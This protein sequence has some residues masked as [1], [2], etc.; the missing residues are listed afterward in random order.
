MNQTRQEKKRIPSIDMLRGIAALSVC[1]FH[2]TNGN[3]YYFSDG[4]WLKTAGSTGWAGVEIFFVISGFI[5]PYSLYQGQYRLK[6]FGLFL[7]KR[8]VRIEPPY[9][10]SILIVIGLSYLS[11]LLPSFK[12][13]PF[14]INYF[15]LMLHVVYLVDFFK[16][17]WLN[18][19]FWTLAIEF[20][21]YLLIGLIF[22]LITSKNYWLFLTVLI[23]LFCSSLII[24]N[25]TIIFHYISY[26]LLGILLF[27]RKFKIN[28]KKHL[29]LLEPLLLI[30][31]YLQFSWVPFMAATF[32]WLIITYFENWQNK[33]ILWMGTISY[34]L[35]LIHV[36]IGG[37]MIN[38]SANFFKTDA[39]RSLAL[40]ITLFLTC[41]LAYLFHLLIEKPAIR[42]SHAIFKKRQTNRPA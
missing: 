32:A 37:R 15:G 34:S 39:S 10:F 28:A 41:L 16:Q 4:Y 29:W 38:F 36:P 33:L 24:R 6:N 8:M 18:P 20:Q 19:V 27:T 25:Q 21:F 22:P 5:I 17:L 13:E 11:P 1:I 23:L 14:H 26:F 3:Q 12:G 2:F 42:F 31:I 7:S 9:F 30:V 40:L 35:Y